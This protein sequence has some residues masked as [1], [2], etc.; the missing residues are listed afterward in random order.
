MMDPKMQP[1][2]Q[3]KDLE[4]LK[5]LTDPLR[6]QIVEVLS[7]A[8]QT[9]KQVADKLGMTPSNL[10]YHINQL[11]KH[12]LIVVE[13]TRMVGNM[14]ERVYRAAA[15]EIS[16]D[17]NLL[18]VSTMEGKES[19]F[20]MVK[21]AIDTTRDDLL[22]SLNARFLQLDQGAEEKPRFVLLS[23]STA[24]IP[25]DRAAEFQQRLKEII[26]EFEASDVDRDTAQTKNF[27]L[28]VVMYPSFYFD[29]Q[30]E[31]K[32]TGGAEDEQ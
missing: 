7:Q 14:V 6:A 9:V 26:H 17:P 13:E 12:A 10:Y 16:L 11:E 28:T 25:E 20:T 5:I 8:P 3:I 22:R 18:T 2:F 32:S 23:R 31:G 30:V 21:Q 15:K 27:A 24:N 4:T 19:L 1:V 29:E